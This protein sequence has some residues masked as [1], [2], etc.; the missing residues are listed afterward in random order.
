M[1]TKEQE[2]Q[3]RKERKARQEER[4]KY[5]F[6]RW[7]YHAT[8]LGEYLIDRLTHKEEPKNWFDAWNDRSE[9]QFNH[10]ASLVRSVVKGLTLNETVKEED[11]DRRIYQY[12]YNDTVLLQ[13]VIHKGNYILEFPCMDEIVG[14]D[15]TRYADNPLLPFLAFYSKFDTYIYGPQQGLYE[16]Y[17]QMLMGYM[18]YKFPE[19]RDRFMPKKK[20]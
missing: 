11:D 12:S 8:K 6:E 7:G 19:T 5:E 4:Q 2:E 14:G 20:G 15:R 10:L 9:E 1:A 3:W 13:V 16:L 17:Y 18:V